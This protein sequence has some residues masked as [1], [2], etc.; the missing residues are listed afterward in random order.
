MAAQKKKKNAIDVL[1]IVF[2]FV[3]FLNTFTLLHF[4]GRTR[5]KKWTD[6]GW[7]I[8]AVNIV[9][10][11]ALVGAFA[12][13]QAQIVPIP[14]DTKPD[15][16]DFIDRQTYDSYTYEER[17]RLPEY[18]AYQEAVDEW[19]RS[20]AY[21]DA[22]NANRRFRSAMGAVEIGALIAGFVAN[23]I[24]F[25]Y[26]ISQKQ[27]YF[28]ALSG[29][30]ISEKAAVY[31]RLRETESPAAAPQPAAPAAPPQ[32][33]AP[34]PPDSARIDVNTADRDALAALPGLTIVDAM[35]AVQYRGEHGPFASVDAFFSAIGAKPH[36]IAKL[37]PSLTAS[38]PAAA[39]DDAPRP[40]RSID[41]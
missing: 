33:D 30:D 17:T 18:Y 3:P 24:L 34:A 28:D 38:Q 11:I 19:Y 25:F 23:L 36:V 39:D 5:R 29:G 37:E 20:P 4:G 22:Y 12:A 35:K 15:V 27:A 41:I 7:I 6:R 9:L 26:V 2:S 14:Y 32:G 10:T 13:R 16:Y 31:Q 8:L 1:L 21:T 40:A